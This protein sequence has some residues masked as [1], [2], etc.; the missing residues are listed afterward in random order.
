M[1]DHQFNRRFFM[2][3]SAAAAVGL[4]A[5]PA[6]AQTP[7]AQPSNLGPVTLGDPTART[8]ST[9]EVNGARIFY[10]VT[11]AGAPMLLLHGYPLSGALFSRVRDELSRDF[12]VITLDHRGYGNSQA[13]AIPDSIEVYADDALAVMQRLNIAKAHIGG[14]SMGGPIAF[15]MYR[16]A[17][18]RFAGMML[19]DT[20]AGAASPAEAGM[21]R[22]V[23][24]MVRQKGVDAL[25]PVLVHEMLS[26]DTRLA[27]PEMVDY[28]KTIV[29]QAS[30]DAAIGG[31]L[32]LAQRPDSTQML[33][34]IHVP[35]Q[36]LVG[37]ND[38]VYPVEI[39][40]GMNEQIT[41]SRLDIIGGAAHAAIFEAPEQCAQAIRAFHGTLR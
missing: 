21:W 31:A 20:I 11:G 16:K 37:L 28:I 17:P 36:I 24:D 41:N 35:V 29:L 9:M 14:M 6:L 39:A 10:Q 23:A 27:Q 19:I 40:R 18:E 30:R 32:A 1:S 15:E 22:G 13:P 7:A 4:A 33:G 25:P 34:S 5:A 8:G 3:G 38:H 26:G 12:Q 2:G